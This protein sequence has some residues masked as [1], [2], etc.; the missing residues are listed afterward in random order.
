MYLEVLRMVP[1]SG[2]KSNQLTNNET[3]IVYEQQHVKD[4]NGKEKEG[5]LTTLHNC[6]SLNVDLI[7]NWR[8]KVFACES[9]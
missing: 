4:A 7:I 2:T 8:K 1:K 9:K 6:C 5:D 3:Q